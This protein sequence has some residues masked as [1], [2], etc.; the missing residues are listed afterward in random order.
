MSDQE[1][2]QSLGEALL[3]FQERAIKIT[4]NATATVKGMSKGGKA[5]EYDYDYLTLDKLLDE[6]LPHLTELGLL[7]TAKPTTLADGS[8]GLRYRMLHVSS[9]QEDGDTMSLMLRQGTPQDQGAAISFAR[10][11]A[12]LAY[13]NL[14]PDKDEDGQIS[15]P[16]QGGQKGVKKI[17]KAKAQ[18]LVEQA[19]QAGVLDKLQ[20][21]ANWEHKADVGSCATKEQATTALQKLNAQEAEAVAKWIAKKAQEALA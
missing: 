11:Y 13:L 3:R 2:P 8:P 5:F 15:T 9:G 1:T 14:A 21:A 4:K 6:V 7:W 18:Q 17:T 19:E 12:V 16:Q 10:R 20:L